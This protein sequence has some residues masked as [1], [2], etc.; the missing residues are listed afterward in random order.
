MAFNPTEMKAIGLY[1]GTHNCIP[2]LS[3]RPMVRFMN[4]ETK[5]I[6]ERHIIVLKTELEESK[7]EE[8]L[9]K[10]RGVKR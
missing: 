10:K 5:E 8:R 2:Q 7:K 1:A 9:N 4:R 6:T 3:V